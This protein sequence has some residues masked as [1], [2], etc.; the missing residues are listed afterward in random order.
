[1][2][3]DD[4]DKLLA[5]RLYLQRFVSQVHNEVQT[6]LSPL[7]EKLIAE[8]SEFFGDASE[9]SRVAMSKQRSHDAH[10]TEFQTTVNDIFRQQQVATANTVAAN[11]ESMV[12]REITYTQKVFDNTGEE[13]S[14]RGIATAAFAGLTIAAR[15]RKAALTFRTRV[16]SDLSAIALSNPEAAARIL[17]GTK[18]ENRRDGII[19]WRNERILRPE[20]DY[21]VN[22]YAGR[23]AEAVYRKGGV[24]QVAWLATL[25][26]RTC[27]TCRRNEE[28]SPYLL[29]Q[30][31]QVGAHPRCRCVITPVTPGQ[32]Q[33][34]RPYV[35]DFRSVKDIPK[36]ERPGKIGQTRDTIEQ[37]FNRMDDGELREYLGPGRFELWKSGKVTSVKNLVD[38]ATLRPLKIDE[39]PK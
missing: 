35:E 31:P 1:M 10:A 19:H 29:G 11:V 18:A 27:V 32:Q 37:F 17:R 4:I 26:F 20:I 22:G 8:V 2:N 39:L 13:P 5:R 3:Q 38:E 21:A 24:E 7:D 33:I 9:R 34:E 30:N 15:F 6:E 14:S 25:D 28:S 12:E 23:A 36:H 16:I